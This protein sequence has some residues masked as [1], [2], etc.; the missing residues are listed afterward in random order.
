[1]GRLLCTVVLLAVA[2]ASSSATP[3]ALLQI[4]TSDVLDKHTG[5]IDV[6][7][8]MYMGARPRAGDFLVDTQFATSSNVE[9][10]YDF[11][12]D[13][14][15]GGILNAKWRFDDEGRTT[16]AAGFQGLEARDLLEP[17]V[18]V[19]GQRTHEKWCYHLGA[20]WDTPGGHG[21]AFGGVSYATNDHFTWMADYVSGAD[22]AATAGF[23]TTFG[24]DDDWCLMVGYVRDNEGGG[25]GAY[26]DLG[27]LIT[28]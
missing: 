23:S 21:H 10:G 24:E 3:T 1:M 2:C 5:F 15:T 14:P 17:F 8:T 27:S 26:V 19:V 7:G 9:F 11:P 13:D 4:P 18:Y 16:W 28:F 25:K 22:G 20:A 6:G 12:A